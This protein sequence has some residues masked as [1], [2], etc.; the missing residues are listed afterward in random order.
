MI[1]VGGVELYMGPVVLGAPDDLDAVVGSFID[2]A[3]D[4]L[5]I[6]VLLHPELV[7]AEAPYRVDVETGSG[8]TRGYSAMAWDKFDLP[9]NALVVEAVDSGRFLGLLEQLLHTRTEP[10]HPIAGM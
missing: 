3:A 8:L 1:R 4:S 6:A 2:G 5:A 10:T 9:P 7:L